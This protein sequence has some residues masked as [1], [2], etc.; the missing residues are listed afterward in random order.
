MN[1][2]GNEKPITSRRA[3]PTPQHGSPP[4][5]TALGE[6]TSSFFDVCGNRAGCKFFNILLQRWVT[7]KPSPACLWADHRKD[8]FP[9]NP[10]PSL[11][12]RDRSCQVSV[13][14]WP[15]RIL[16]YSN[17]AGTISFPFHA[18]FL[19]NHDG[20]HCVRPFLRP[21]ILEISIRAI[22]AIFTIR[23]RQIACKTRYSK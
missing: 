13:F 23:P 5:K 12:L 20:I 3:P 18:Y 11:R 9:Y 4:S 17:Q 21:P 8:S 14:S 6:S 7:V 16:D 2:R 19:R 15:S 1:H 22:H 10:N